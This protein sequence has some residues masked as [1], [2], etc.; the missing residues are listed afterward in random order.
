MAAKWTEEEDALLLKLRAEGYTSKEMIHFI[1]GRTHAAI[2]TRLSKI[3]TDNL[4][5]P[6]SSQETQLVL[7]LKAQGRSLKFIARQVDRTPRAVG[8]HIARYWENVASNT[9]VET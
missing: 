5:R 8:S 9:S 7:D 3:A 1:K 2:R 4:N 6:W